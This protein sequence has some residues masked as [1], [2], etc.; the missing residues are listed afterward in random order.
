LP[1]NTDA[2]QTGCF[3]WFGCILGQAI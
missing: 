2:R 1:F 3:V